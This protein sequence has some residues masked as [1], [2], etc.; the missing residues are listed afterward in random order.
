MSTTKQ[1]NTYLLIYLCNQISELEKEGY[2][3]EC[4]IIINETIQQLKR[5]GGEKWDKWNTQS[6]K[7]AK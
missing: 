6:H 5:L 3:K 2:E 4:S 1:V 7:K